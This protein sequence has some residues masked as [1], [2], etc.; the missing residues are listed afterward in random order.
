MER[1]G[2][3]AYAG[4]LFAAAII[5]RFA[6][7]SNDSFP[8][9][10]QAEHLSVHDPSTF[11]NA[12]F[13]IGYPVLLR[14]AGYLGSPFV[15]LEIV[16]VFLSAIYFR[17]VAQLARTQLG[18]GAALIALPFL[19][20][21]SQIL[22]DELSVVPDII[23]ALFVML[24]LVELAGPTEADNSKIAR[25][26]S[27]NATHDLRAGLW[28]GVGLLFRTHVAAFVFA[29]VLALV[30]IER[31]E[32]LRRIGMLLMGALPFILI[33]GVIQVWSGHG[34]F[35]TGQGFNVWKT[36]HELDWS[37]PPVYFSLTPWQAIANEPWIFAR[38]YGA[39]FLE[40][41]YLVLPLAVFL[42]VAR[43]RREHVGSLGELALATLFYLLITLPGGSARAV[44]PVLP[45][46]VLCVVALLRR[47]TLSQVLL[48]TRNASAI[49]IIFAFIGMVSVFAG[50]FS[51]R[52]RTEIYNSLQ[53]TTGA[54]LPQDV[55]SIYSDDYALYFPDLNDATPRHSGGWAE[56]GLP[57]YLKSNPHIPDSTERSWYESLLQ[58]HIS[59]AALREPPLD[60]RV[61][62]FAV[63]DTLHF[64]KI[65]F[66]EGYNVYRLR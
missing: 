45:I 7:L 35:E 44:A 24:A 39:L 31:R 62:D 11:Y 1:W 13:P 66:A 55:M 8:L 19:L 25:P 59:F 6:V 36:M 27:S 16:Q 60:R 49:F 57:H 61:A 3:F 54:T 40:Q 52:H 30:V 23:A 38:T 12:F 10:W 32:S 42:I 26:S 2:P 21:S 41:L 4:L 63:T 53:R 20:F 43:V 58:N 5:S 65:P 17:K 47:L 9:R 29:L 50:A 28:L 33:Q 64:L 15:V 37:N 14:L 51:A 46:A 22:R 34:F 48:R 56:V 18:Y